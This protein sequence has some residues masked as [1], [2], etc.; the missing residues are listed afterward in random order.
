MQGYNCEYFTNKK[1]KN[2]VVVTMGLEPMTNGLLDQRS[3][4]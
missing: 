3:T 1:I 2:N 4:D